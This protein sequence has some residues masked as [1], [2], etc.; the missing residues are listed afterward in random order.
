MIVLASGRRHPHQMFVLALSLLL[1]VAYLVRVPAPQSL[2]AVAPKWVVVLWSVGLVLSG[3][4]GLLGCLWLGQV[5]VGL[6]LERGA[7]LLST[8]A[9]V[10]I[11]SASVAANGSRA[12]FGVGVIT[13]WALANVA[14][15]VQIT[16]NLRQI[17]AAVEESADD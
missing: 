9:L 1:G 16:N 8:A 2:A 7:L 3:A 13:A 12:L 10:L 4:V 14:R 6:G 15:C 11:G 17:T 5:E